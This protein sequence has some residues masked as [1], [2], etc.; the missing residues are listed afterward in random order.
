MGTAVAQ[1]A[2][3]KCP[4]GAGGQPTKS[5]EGVS[6]V[7]TSVDAS[8]SFNDTCNISAMIMLSLWIPEKTLGHRY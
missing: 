3:Y 4:V 1:R 8:T 6:S 5:G 7:V 2:L